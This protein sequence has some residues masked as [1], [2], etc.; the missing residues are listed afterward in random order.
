MKKVN[1]KILLPGLIVT[2]LLGACEKQLDIPSR[3]SLD[4][5]VALTTKSGI[6][7]S[8]NSIYL[9]YFCISKI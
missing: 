5:S 4:A 3:N 9:I 7:N 6:E 1:F 2:M 8:I